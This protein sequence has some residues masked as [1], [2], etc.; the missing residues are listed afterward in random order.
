MA[1]APRHLAPGESDIR[2]ASPVTGSR[3]VVRE[4]QLLVAAIRGG[5][6][7]ALRRLYE[8]HSRLLL[9]IA[10]ETLQDWESAEEVVQDVFIQCWEQASRYRESQASPAAWL[11]NMTR[12]RAIDRLRSSR[13]AKR[14]GGQV[15]P[16]QD[17]PE[18]LLVLRGHV[19]S[20]METGD[21]ATVLRELPA[22]VRTAILLAALGGL[23][24]AEIAEFMEAPQG[25]VKSWIRRGL[26]RLREQLAAGRTGHD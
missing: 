17:V 22:E 6:Q 4:D 2:Q 7:L 18:G 24:H 1:I 13:A 10:F 23:T 16:L 14:G 9:H 3:D 11:V 21:L 8:R 19:G 20:R 15:L 5:D 25:T 12:S 26:L